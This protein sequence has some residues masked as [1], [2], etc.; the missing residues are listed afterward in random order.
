M[1]LERAMQKCALQV[2]NYMYK[3]LAVQTSTTQKIKYMQCNHS[4]YY[5]RLG[6][7]LGDKT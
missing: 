5:A 2:H 4:K 7:T 1:V 3:Y 6:Q